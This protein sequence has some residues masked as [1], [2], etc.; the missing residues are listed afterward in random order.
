MHPV[1]WAFAARTAE[2]LTGWPQAEA[3]WRSVR[4]WETLRELRDWGRL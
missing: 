4:T 2:A 1:D 3:E